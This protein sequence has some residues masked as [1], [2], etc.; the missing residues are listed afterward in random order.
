MFSVFGGLALV[1]A[2]VGLFGVL[3]YSVNQRRQELGVR[4]A[5][6]AQSG[7]LIRLVVWEGLR[8][9][10]VGLSVGVVIAIAVGHFVAPLLFEASPWDP[11]VFIAV[12]VT[13]V[14]VA[15]FASLLPARRASRVNPMEALRSE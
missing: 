10:L 6:G 11:A 9:V 2:A 3:S 7:S 14:S 4:T 15:F 12:A 1:L 13:L 5:L 8:V